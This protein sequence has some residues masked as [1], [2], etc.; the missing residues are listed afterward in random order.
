MTS[1][2]YSFISVLNLSMFSL[3]IDNF[4]LGKINVLQSITALLPKSVEL[5]LSFK[6]RILI[7]LI[8]TAYK[9]RET[10]KARPN[11]LRI[12]RNKNKIAFFVEQSETS[13]R[14]NLGGQGTQIELAQ[15]RELL[16]A[17]KG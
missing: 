9:L 12:T 5:F 16:I 8:A 13:S 6:N 4:Q 1:E 10:K 2:I 17:R 11:S 14:Q 15:R 3:N 7:F